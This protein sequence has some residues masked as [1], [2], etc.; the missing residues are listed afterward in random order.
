MNAGTLADPSPVG[1]AHATDNSYHPTFTGQLVGQAEGPDLREQNVPIR[2]GRLR[3][4]G[5]RN[6]LKY[7]A[8]WRRVGN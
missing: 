6:I 7:G 5:I 1:P 8:A 3:P 2:V 4:L